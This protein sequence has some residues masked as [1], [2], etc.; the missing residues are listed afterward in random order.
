ME[1]LIHI[2][3]FTLKEYKIEVGN[4]INWLTEST[5]IRRP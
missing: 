2:F 3:L 4:E 1:I 5:E